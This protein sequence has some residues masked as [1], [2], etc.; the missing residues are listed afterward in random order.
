MVRTPSPVSH[1]GRNK[2]RGYSA[3]PVPA[4]FMRKGKLGKG[5]I[6]LTPS[7][8]G[9]LSMNSA[10]NEEV[11]G[12]DDISGREN[13]PEAPKLVDEIK[14][15]K[16]K[17]KERKLKNKNK[18]VGFDLRNE[19]MA[20]DPEDDLNQLTIDI[21]DIDSTNFK[22]KEMQMRIDLLKCHMFGVVI[23]SFD[24]NTLNL[25]KFMRKDFD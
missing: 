23:H 22:E 19:K 15:E 14:V 9:E 20:K 17:L 1:R 3:S 24:S 16:Q 5:G 25:L 7:L 6:S 12:M 2:K 8:G 18:K 21:K 4:K 13:S 11:D 10:S